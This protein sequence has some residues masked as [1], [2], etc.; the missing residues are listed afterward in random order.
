[1]DLVF[2]KAP[3]KWD[4]YVSILFVL[5]K[6][7]SESVRFR[8]ITS[9]P[10]IVAWNNN[11]LF[12][13]WCHAS[14]IW[15]GHSWTVFIVSCAKF[16]HL[17][18]APPQLGTGWSRMLSAG[19]AHLSS[20]W[21]LILSNPPLSFL[22]MMAGQGSKKESHTVQCSWGLISELAHCHFCWILLANAYPKASPD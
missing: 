6:K 20:M 17:W 9:H 15:H 22:H 11:H 1:M 16:V 14:Q 12:S 2:Q 21:P 7:P 19:R 4:L 18:A 10:Q 8:S 13:S 3:K 5:M